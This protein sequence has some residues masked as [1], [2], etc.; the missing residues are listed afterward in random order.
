VPSP[1][2]DPVD[3]EEQSEI[4][5]RKFEEINAA[6]SAI[7]GV[8]SANSNIASTYET[9]KQQ[10]P[11]VESIN[12]FLAAHQMATT[13]LAVKYC[14]ELVGELGET[15][16]ARSQFFPNFNFSAGVD[17]AFDTAGRQNIIGPLQDH[18][19]LNSGLASQ[20]DPLDMAL[21]LNSLIDI[22]RA[23]CP[24]SCSS[25][26]DRT[27]KIVKATCAAAVGSAAMLLQ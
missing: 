2:P 16:T 25:E 9:V 10:L 8:S 12:G 20:P 26:P 4:G 23:S 7:T 13:Q 24:G 27:L 1:L 19:L 21:E 15:N 22:M 6:L 3:L 5:L 18:L 11:T 17:S 14:S